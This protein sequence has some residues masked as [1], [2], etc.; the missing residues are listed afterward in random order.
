M[1][2]QNKIDAALT[3]CGMNQ[4][5]CNTFINTSGLGDIAIL[6]TLDECNEKG[7]VCD[8]LLKLPVNR[9][10]AYIPTPQEKNL[11]SKFAEMR[12]IMQANRDN[13][14]D[15]TTIGTQ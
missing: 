5:M 11:C 8:N 1:H 6:T 15:N 7:M 4:A 9:G 14:A 3:V 12:A 2:K 13:D 10:W